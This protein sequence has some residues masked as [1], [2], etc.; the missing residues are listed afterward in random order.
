MMAKPSIQTFQLYDYNACCEYIEQKY[1]INLN[2]VLGNSKKQREH[3]LPPPSNSS[4][5]VREAYNQRYT[6][7]IHL[8]PVLSFHNETMGL[9][10]IIYLSNDFDDMEPWF[11][12]IV[13]LFFD[14]FAIDGEVPLFYER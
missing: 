6:E 4:Y 14:E 2:D 10:P 7:A 1:N 8:Y 3:I 12:E 13:K 11:A 9:G 5:E